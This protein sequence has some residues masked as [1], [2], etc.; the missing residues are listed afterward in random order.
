MLDTT[1]NQLKYNFADFTFSEYK[2]L[3]CIAKA[4]Y[5]FRL[6]DEIEPQDDF[7][8]WRHDIDFS[9]DS[10]L[11]LANIEYENQIRSTFFIHLHSEFYNPL[12]KHTT[13]KINNILKLGHDIGV[14]FDFGFYDRN[15][16]MMERYLN[17]EKEILETTFQREVKVFSFHNP[18]EF[19]LTCEDYQYA[20][21]VNTYAQFFKTQVGYC[22]DSNGYWRHKRMKDYLMETEEA[23]LQ[24]LTHPNWWSE[25][26]LSPKQKI[27][28]CIEQRSATTYAQY[29]DSLALHSRENIDW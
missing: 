5:E 9:V 11:K 2:K 24:I 18:T 28:S 20:N 4:K 3:L 7:I 1:E 13:E 12:E 26:V 17:M 14:H 10:S 6:Y 8:L 22:S 15:V 29:E 23:R 27:V 19:E 25:K 21:M 16:P